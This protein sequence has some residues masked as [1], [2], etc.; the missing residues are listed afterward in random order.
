MFKSG[1][2]KGTAFAAGTSRAQDANILTRTDLD[3]DEHLDLMVG[4][5]LVLT[6]ASLR[7]V[8]IDP[9]L[10][11]SPRRMTFPD[12]TLFETEDH[13]A[14]ATLTGATHGDRLHWLEGFHPRL[15]AVVAAAVVGVWLLWRYGLDILAGAAIA[16]TPNVMVEQIDRGTLSSIDFTMAS[17]TAIEETEQARVRAVFDKLV[18]TMEPSDK[19]ETT[20]ELLFRSMPRVGPNAFAMPGGTVVITDQFVQ[21]FKDEDI[22]AGVFGHEIGHVVEQHGLRQVYRSLSIYVLIAF[23]AGDTGPVIEDIVLEGNL[24]LSL[25][26][27]RAHELSA[28]E[29]GLTLADAAGFDPAGLKT[30]FRYVIGLG[31]EQPEWLSSHPSSKARIDAIDAFLERLNK[32]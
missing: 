11:S 18:A 9:R 26:Y 22:L 15:I 21:R 2:I 12:G 31:G 17:P 25:N 3:G 29:Y 7:E 10:G 14:I 20:F 27:S 32:S 28:D 5:D 1:G 23:L 6:G 19:G 13:D 16:L 4:D 24:L 8:Q 30:F